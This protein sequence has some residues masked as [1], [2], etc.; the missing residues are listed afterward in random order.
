MEVAAGMVPPITNSR[1]VGVMRADLEEVLHGGS[2]GNAPFRVR[3]LGS[4]PPHGQYPGWVSQPG[5]VMAHRITPMT[6]IQQDLAL[7]SAGGSN[8]GSGSEGDEGLHTEETEC[9]GSLNHY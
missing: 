7:T 4:S 3:D 6:L 9:G 1:V 8:E 2:P 5:G